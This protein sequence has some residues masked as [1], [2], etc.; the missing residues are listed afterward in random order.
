MKLR[1]LQYNLSLLRNV[2]FAPEVI[3]AK[4]LVLKNRQPQID[5][6]EKQ[7]RDLQAKRPASKPRWPENTPANVLKRCEKFW[8]G[9]TEFRKFRIHAWNDKIIITSFPSGAFWNNSG[10]NAASS[11][12]YAIS[13]SE[14]QYSKPKEICS[15]S[16]R[17]S[18]LD[19][20][21][22]LDGKTPQAQVKPVS[23]PEIV[24]YKKVDL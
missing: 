16:G 10:R 5:V 13:R 9:T 24:Q 19:I 17:V 2:S 21:A 3:A 4:E 14:D 15:K 6:L 12:Y 18:K 7:I 23:V 1:Q 22:M 20:E 11:C 8:E